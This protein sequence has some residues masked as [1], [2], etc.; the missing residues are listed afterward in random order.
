[1]RLHNI[2]LMT[3][4]LAAAAIWAGASMS[5]MGSFVTYSASSGGLAASATFDLT[6]STL[7][8][9]LANTATSDVLVP[10]DVLTAVFFDTT[11]VL[12]HDTASLNGSSVYYGSIVNNIGEGW[13]Y[14]GGIS[15]HGMNAGIS[16]TGLGIFGGNQNDPRWFY[17]PAQNPVD[18]INYGILSVGD[19]PA[20]DNG[21]ITSGGPLVKNSIVFSLTV[22]SGFSLS[23]LGNSVV[24]QYGTALDEPNFT[25]PQTGG[26]PVPEPTTMLAGALLLLPFGVSTLRVLR[27]SRKA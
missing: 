17:T 21:G 20:T 4:L 26:S 14:S 2:K 22:G 27:K 13:Q 24:F 6:G 8:V 16:A 11:H 10:T 3:A 25:A 12:T 1:M 9:T 18:G 15:A 19:N 7:T 5:A 23:E